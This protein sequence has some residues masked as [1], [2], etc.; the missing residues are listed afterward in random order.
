MAT[1]DD[2]IVVDDDNNSTSYI[3][4]FIEA[5]GN[6]D[7]QTFQRL[8]P[9]I[10]ASNNPPGYLTEGLFAL[11][12]TLG[13]CSTFTPLLQDSLTILH[14]L[15]FEGANVNYF[16]GDDEGNDTYKLSVIHRACTWSTEEVIS[17][18]LKYGA[19]PCSEGHRGNT[20]LH[21]ACS[22]RR[23]PAIILQLIMAGADCNAKNFFNKTPLDVAFDEATHPGNEDYFKVCSLLQSQG[24]DPCNTP[25][26]ICGISSSNE[27]MF[28][29]SLSVRESTREYVK[30]QS[31]IVFDQDLPDHSRDPK[32]KRNQ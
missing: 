17:A 22:H 8:L 32:R 6:F 26:A 3:N 12:G 27:V 7:L 18:L 10:L 24:A 5:C 15:V 30:R 23:S 19:N 16:E 4:L 29:N 25:R 20:P 21:Q 14:K 13:V 2:T 31:P 1:Q 28:C 11:V 9:A